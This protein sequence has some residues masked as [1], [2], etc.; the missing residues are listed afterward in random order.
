[1]GS[2]AGLNYTYWTDASATTVLANPNALV[3]GGTYYI[4]ATSAAGCTIIKT[5][6]Q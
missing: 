6:Y 5:S 4:R 2:D 1:V 3:T